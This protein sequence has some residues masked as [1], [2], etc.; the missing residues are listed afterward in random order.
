MS[1]INILWID[2]EIDLLKVHIL[3]LEERGF[4]VKTSNNAE[5]GFEIIKKNKFDIVFLDENMPGTSGLEILPRI[6]REFPNLPIIMVTKREEEDV[7][8]DAIGSKVDGYLIKP[9]KPNQILLAIKQNVQ[10]KDILGEKTIQKYQTDFRELADKIYLAQNFQEW[11]DIYK[12]I[13][14]WELELEKANLPQMIEILQEQKVDANKHFSKFIQKNYSSWIK[15]EEQRPLMLNDLMRKK[16]KPL[17][18]NGDKVF[19]IVMDNFRFDQWKILKPY[20]EKYLNVDSEEIVSGI[21][22]TTTQYARN[23]F[24]SGLL[25][26]KIAERYPDF[27]SDEEDEGNKNDF[28][29]QLVKEFFSRNRRDIKISYSKIFNEEF[30]NSKLKNIKALYANDLNI[31]VFNFI[32]LLSHAKTNIQMVKDLAKDEKAY[33]NLVK[34]W[35]ED[36]YLHFLL[37]EISGTNIKLVLTTDHGTVLV[38]NPVKV[39]GDRHSSTNIRYKQGRNLNFDDKSVFEISNPEEFGLP[40]SSITSSFI[41]AQNYDFLVYPKNYHQF[42]KYYKDTFQHGGISMEEMLIPFITFSGK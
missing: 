38:K 26:L 37:Q 14:F 40:K 8:D 16:I 27:W 11:T 33:R 17:I 35:F 31:F 28:E 22:P 23:S 21:L 10:Q 19:L 2:D 5:D 18:D 6:K 39:I 12:N 29:F 32:D 1:P 20:F 41:F 24:F 3:L 34:V 13:V 25:P 9:V 15:D 4:V 42:A 36:S 7:M 30:A